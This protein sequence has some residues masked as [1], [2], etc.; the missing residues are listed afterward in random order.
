[1]LTQEIMLKTDILL[2][3]IRFCLKK[4]KRTK[5]LGTGVKV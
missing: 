3:E 5:R 2:L 1:M 4:E